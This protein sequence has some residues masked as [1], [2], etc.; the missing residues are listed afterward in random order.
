[1]YTTRTVIPFPILSPT[2][3]KFVDIPGGD[4]CRRHW[5][6]VATDFGTF[7]KLRPTKRLMKW[8]F[9]SNLMHHWCR[10][11]YNNHYDNKPGYKNQICTKVSKKQLDKKLTVSFG[12]EDEAGSAVL[13]S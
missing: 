2:Y 10:T 3:K 8:F 13:E 4:S 1:M 6:L 5:C 12:L 9:A 11:L 7:L